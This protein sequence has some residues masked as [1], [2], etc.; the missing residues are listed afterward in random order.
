MTA[1]ALSVV[2]PTDAPATVRAM[3][4]HLGAQTGAERMEVVLVA[5][6]G[7]TTAASRERVFDV[8]VVEIADVAN[9][10]CA[11]AAG[12]RAARAPLV[13]LAETH[14]YP[15]AG[16]LE[17]T[18]EAARGGWTIVAP[19]FVNANPDR[20][21]SWAS[22]LMDYGPWVAVREGGEWSDVPGHNSAYRRDALL[23]YGDRLEAMLRSDTLLV[24][25]LRRRGHRFALE[26][27]ARI[28]HLNV[29]SRSSWLRERWVGGRTFAALRA[30]PW[31]V[32][33]RA[34][35][36]LGAALI[37]LVR[38]HRIL[39]DVHRVDPTG[40]LARRIAP[41]LGLALVV[42]AAGELWG[43]LTGG[44]DEARLF[45]MELHKARYLAGG[46]REP[47]AGAPA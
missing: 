8:R 18:L 26:P 3:L 17:A 25:D 31:S 36:V 11:R 35:Y 21:T 23:A 12:I 14:A 15:Q 22:L 19:T 47:E 13:V 46:D 30:R 6:P 2:L 38:A 10:P 4:D 39:R 24:D 28:A 27:R 34:G 41:A 42:S 5:P 45:E 43:Y 20:A 44:S 40:R 33:R 29:T 16:W 9:L 1:P 7:V 32:A 37:P